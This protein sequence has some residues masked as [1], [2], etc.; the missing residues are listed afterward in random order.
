MGYTEER[1]KSIDKRI[2]KLADMIGAYDIYVKI[3]MGVVI[4]L[5]LIGI[6]GSIYILCH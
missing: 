4:L 6:V 2:A 5:V 3:S 1:I